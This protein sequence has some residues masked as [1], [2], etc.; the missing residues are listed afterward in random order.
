MPCYGGVDKKQKVTK[1]DL[2]IS[3]LFLKP[4]RLYRWFSPKE[5][6]RCHRFLHSCQKCGSRAFIAQCFLK[7]QSYVV[8]NRIAAKEI[9]ESV[10]FL[11][12]DH[13]GNVFDV[14][15]KTTLSMT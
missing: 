4:H 13:A 14:H 10:Y 12:D 2:E 7:L 5:H 3:K 11:M 6:G 15:N 1:P 9:L 8:Y